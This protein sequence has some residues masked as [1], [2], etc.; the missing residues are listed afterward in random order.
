V[1]FAE[2]LG[3]TLAYC[4]T[5][6]VLEGCFP[7]QPL[8]R[9]LFILH[10]PQTQ[11]CVPVLRACIANY[12]DLFPPDCLNA[13]RNW[14]LFSGSPANQLSSALPWIAIFW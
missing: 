2:I 8:A 1:L 6:V 5:P 10:K 4:Q 14:S 7:E 12:L 13:C 9:S 3:F 11:Q